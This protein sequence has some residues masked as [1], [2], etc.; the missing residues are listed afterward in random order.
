VV[1]RQQVMTSNIH[2]ISKLWSNV[3]ISLLKILSRIAKH[4]CLSCILGLG[5][6]VYLTEYIVEQRRRW[7]GEDENQSLKR[8]F[9]NHYLV[10]PSLCLKNMQLSG[11][12]VQICPPKLCSIREAGIVLIDQGLVIRDNARANRH[13]P[14]EIASDTRCSN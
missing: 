3:T 13:R 8:Q 10:L 12:I 1:S 14:P 11:S 2:A 9:G 7:T 6:T 4:H 5:Q